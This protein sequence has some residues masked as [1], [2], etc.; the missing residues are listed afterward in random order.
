MYT[1][2]LETILILVL[3]AFIIGLIVGI[4]LTQPSRMLR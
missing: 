2:D 4:T 3:V 1:L